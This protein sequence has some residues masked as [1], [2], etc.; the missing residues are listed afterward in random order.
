MGSIKLKVISFD[1]ALFD[2]F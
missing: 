2:G 1:T